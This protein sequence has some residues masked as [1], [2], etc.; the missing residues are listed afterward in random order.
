MIDELTAGHP[1][2]SGEQ[3]G[4]SEEGHAIWLRLQAG[5]VV[6][7]HQRQR[8]RDRSEVRKSS[9]P[10]SSLRLQD[11][12]IVTW[13]FEITQGS[14]IHHRPVK[15]YGSPKTVETGCTT[16]QRNPPVRFRYSSILF[17]SSTVENDGAVAFIH[18]ISGY[19]VLQP[20]TSTEEHE[21]MA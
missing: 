20:L 21:P 18:R 7:K 17:A 15:A 9:P 14:R 11:L 16:T 3:G 8:C 10:P 6:R 19:N 13:G 4:G 12:D 5:G 1:S 2:Q